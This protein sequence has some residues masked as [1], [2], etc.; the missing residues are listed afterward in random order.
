[1]RQMPGEYYQACRCDK[2]KITLADRVIRVKAQ[3]LD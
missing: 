3:N 2:M 1:M